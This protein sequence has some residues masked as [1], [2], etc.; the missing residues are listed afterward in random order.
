MLLQVTVNCPGLKPGFT[1]YVA[2]AARSAAPMPSKLNASA[3]SA[4]PRK[5]SKSL[6][7]PVTIQ[8]SGLIGSETSRMLSP[9][10]VARINGEPSNERIF[11]VTRRSTVTGLAPGLVRISRYRAK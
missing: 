4:K 7:S 9:E 6:L 11:D 5:G 8:R 3:G 2:E 10:E 1:A